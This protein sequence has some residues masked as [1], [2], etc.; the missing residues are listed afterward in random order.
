MLAFLR[1][2]GGALHPLNLTTGKNHFLDCPQRDRWKKPKRQR[3][4]AVQA[5]QL[6]LLGDDV[7][8]SPPPRAR[9][10]YDD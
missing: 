9:G 3:A 5:E 10:H 6:T 4:P 7:A 2:P 1:M 8:T